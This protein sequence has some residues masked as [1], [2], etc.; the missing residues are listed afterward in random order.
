MVIA[1]DVVTLDLNAAGRLELAELPTGT[2][3]LSAALPAGAVVYARVGRRE[4]PRIDLARRP[5][6]RSSCEPFG[7]LVLEWEELAGGTADILVGADLETA[8]VVAEA[9]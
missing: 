5:L 4:A 3:V 2:N 9:V 6:V 1:Y 8:V 7:I